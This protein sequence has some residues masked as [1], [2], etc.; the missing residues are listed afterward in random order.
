MAYLLAV[1][2]FFPTVPL[3]RAYY[4]TPF[5]YARSA[6]RCISLLPLPYLRLRVYKIKIKNLQILTILVVTKFC[7][8][9][10]GGLV[11][12]LGM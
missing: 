12:G 3:M 10:Y 8:E 4:W 6:D 7:R 2:I 9:H 5:I 11:N 1:I